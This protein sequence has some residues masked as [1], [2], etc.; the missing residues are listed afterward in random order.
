MSVLVSPYGVS[1]NLSANNICHEFKIMR[2]EDQELLEREQEGWD[3]G[4]AVFC[5]RLLI[6]RSWNLIFVLACNVIYTA[7]SEDRISCSQKALFRLQSYDGTLPFV[8][9]R[10][11]KDVWKK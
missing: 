8:R 7:V 9:V 5:V 2:I 4:D 6:P 11:A 1:L 10:S 3:D